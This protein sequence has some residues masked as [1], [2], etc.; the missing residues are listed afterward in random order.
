[1]GVSE[2]INLYGDNACVIKLG[3]DAGVLGNTHLSFA[4]VDDKVANFFKGFLEVIKWL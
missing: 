1:V 2:L 4:D 3:E